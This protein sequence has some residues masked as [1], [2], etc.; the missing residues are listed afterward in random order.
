MADSR[1]HCCTRS[2]T[3]PRQLRP[4]HTTMPQLGKECLQAL[5]DAT[6][7]EVAQGE[8]EERQQIEA[9]QASVAKC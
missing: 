9:L 7:S 3:L 1:C 8:A 5:V 6:A 2:A 4:D